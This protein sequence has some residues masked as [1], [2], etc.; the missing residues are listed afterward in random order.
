MIKYVIMY[1]YATKCFRGQLGKEENLKLA[2]NYWEREADVSNP[3]AVCEMLVD[4]HITVVE[5][6]KEINANIGGLT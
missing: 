3:Q 5:L 2:E 6:V 4:G 1:I